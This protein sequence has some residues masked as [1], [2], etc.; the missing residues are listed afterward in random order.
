M[1]DYSFYSSLA[2]KGFY[3]PL[4]DFMSVDGLGVTTDLGVNGSVTPVNFQYAP[5]G[6]VY[7]HRAIIHL[8]DDGA[9]RASRYGSLNE[10]TNGLEIKILNADDTVDHDYTAGFPIKNI[11]HWGAMCY[12]VDLIT[13]GAGDTVCNVRWTFALAGQPMRIN[14]NVG[15]Y[16]QVVVQDDL[17][18]VTAH[19]IMLQGHT[20][21][22]DQNHG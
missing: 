6:E 2:N 3:E 1:P 13:I 14:G 15:Q 12:D 9:W 20:L 18:S 16:L 8:Q 5:A 7:I 4:Y 21:G 10:L 11:S 22:V 19:T 17:S